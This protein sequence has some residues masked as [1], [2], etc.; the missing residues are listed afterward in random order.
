M[1]KLISVHEAKSRINQNSLKFG[2]E[3][4]NL[5]QS[6]GKVLAEDVLT[7]RPYPPFNRA[8]MDGICL[9]YSDIDLLKHNGLPVHSSIF[10]G[11]EINNIPIGSAAKIMTGA[12]LPNEL[13]TVIRVEDLDFK[14]SLVHLKPSAKVVNGQCVHL[15]GSDHSK[16]DLAIKKGTLIKQGT[17]AAL[18]TI[19]VDRPLVEKLP[20]VAIIA[21][22]NE[23]VPIQTVPKDHQIRTSNTPFLTSLCNSLGLE[24]EAYY[25]T[26]DVAETELLIA[27]LL[28]GF[29]V[30]LFTGGVSKGEKDF[31]AESLEKNEVK[32]IFHGVLQKPG[33]PMWF[34][35]T[36]SCMV[37]A[38]PGNPISV[39]A[40]ATV[41]FSSFI[42]QQAINS[43]ILSEELKFS[44]KLG[45]FHPVSVRTENGI[46]FAD[47]ISFNTSGDV[48]SLA[49]IDGFIELPAKEDI[50][51]PGR[52]FPVYLC[53]HE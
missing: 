48:L 19:G 1:D 16:G 24:N 45:L 49:Y 6:S 46:F 40:T 26:D 33:K 9:R 41:Y 52:S 34:G 22:G 2:T 37:F 42:R 32:K 8:T 7:D 3:R 25:L 14:D 10:A 29:D 28:A 44:K 53:S 20:K 18:A 11:D 15:K 27:Q 30:L 31:V 17:I 35:T 4:V 21:T 51:E 43:A 39:A 12:S 5:I 47:P 36:S 50:F 38:L 23:L 13:D